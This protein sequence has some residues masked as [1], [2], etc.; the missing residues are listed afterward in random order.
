[1]TFFD[2]ILLKNNTYENYDKHG[3][4]NTSG[5]IPLAKKIHEKLLL[6]LLYKLQNK[7]EETSELNI[8]IY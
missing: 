6:L 1:M 7:S 2:F 4:S 8:V 3:Q 5:P